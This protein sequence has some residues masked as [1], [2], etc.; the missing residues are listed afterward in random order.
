MSAAGFLANVFFLL[1]MFP[2]VSPAPL[3]TD[4]QPVVFLVAA[5]MLAFAMRD[6]RLR[7][8]YIDIIF[9]LFSLISIIYVNS[10]YGSFD[11]F[12]IRKTTGPL[13]AML[14]FYVARYFG[15]YMSLKL[16]P[17]A[18]VIYAG[19]GVVQYID[20]E[21][22]AQG[23]TEQVL[24]RGTRTDES[25]YRGITSLCPEP[26]FLACVA[27]FCA[28]L[29][30]CAY[31]RRRQM[32]SRKMLFICVF[33]AGLALATKSGFALLTLG[34]IGVGFLT[35]RFGLGKGILVGVLLGGTLLPFHSL[36]LKGRAAHLV[37]I[38]A[39]DPVS[40]FRETSVL[41]RL[42]PMIVGYYVVFE[43][44]FGTGDV[45][46]K[47][48]ATMVYHR[49]SLGSLAIP[50]Q[51]ILLRGS[52]VNGGSNEVG[53]Y[54][55][56]MGVIFVAFLVLLMLWILRAKCSLLCLMFLVACLFTSF[57]FP[58]PPLWFLIGWNMDVDS[59]SLVLKPH[60]FATP[61]TFAVWTNKA[62]VHKPAIV[63]T[64]QS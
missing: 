24:S 40:T 21:R 63:A 25:Y 46:Y 17:L 48:T 52:L 39:A 10:D 50:S 5:G 7:F 51:E 9:F 58:F 12:A 15:R 47:D 3:S 11:F 38:V 8:D 62:A 26:S 28:L 22:Y 19:F 36:F 1:V 6:S 16:I 56:R 55:V 31:Q 60:I 37:S 13:L 49:E 18:L 53:R 61:T 54:T 32:T 20:P 57:P 43:Y 44:P 23:I 4:V 59:H 29:A 27:L 64:Q 41:E 33:S 45:L 2:F 14:V 30:C 34:V 42:L 35:S